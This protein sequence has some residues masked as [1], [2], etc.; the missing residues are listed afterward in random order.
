MN[1]PRDQRCIALL[2]FIREYQAAHGYA[3]TLREMLT[4]PGS[5]RQRAW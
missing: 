3:P 1:K 5:P 2:A 4:E